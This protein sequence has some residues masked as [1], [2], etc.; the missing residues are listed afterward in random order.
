MTSTSLW[1]LLLPAWMLVAGGICIGVWLKTWMQDAGEPEPPDWV[2]PQPRHVR[3][4]K[5]PR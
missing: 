4:V 2:Q 3:V 5:P 1:L